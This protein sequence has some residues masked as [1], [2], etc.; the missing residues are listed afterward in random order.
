MNSIIPILRASTYFVV[1]LCFAWATKA[2]DDQGP[3]FS[4]YNTLPEVDG[5]NIDLFHDWSCAKFHL[6]YANAERNELVL[7]LNGRQ[8]SVEHIAEVVAD[9]CYRF[10]HDPIEMSL[11]SLY[12]DRTVPMK[13]VRRVERELR[14][15]NYVV[16]RYAVRLKR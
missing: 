16:V 11:V 6:G 9:Y 8:V 13:M 15:G 10:D 2:F 7:T 12:I 3:Y 4:T 1:L 14:E 5:D